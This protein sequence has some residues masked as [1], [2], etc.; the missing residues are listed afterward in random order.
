MGGGGGGSNIS[1]QLI[2]IDIAS[3]QNLLQIQSKQ[4]INKMSTWGIYWQ[5]CLRVSSN[6]QNICLQNLLEKPTER[7]TRKDNALAMVQCKVLKQLQLLE[8]RK[9]DDPD[10]EEDIEFLNEHLQAS[11]QDLRCVFLY[12]T[13]MHM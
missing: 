1:H 5:P 3:V 10:I 12:G 11:V 13:C 6:D 7:E 2:I 4:E 9:F 8:G